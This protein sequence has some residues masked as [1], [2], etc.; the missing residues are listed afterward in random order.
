MKS[1][2][3]TSNEHPS[4]NGKFVHRTAE[5]SEK[6]AVGE[7]TKVWNNAQIREQASVG[8]NCIIGKNA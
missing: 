6:A 2:L 4:S 5:V 1:A 8:R 7:G 3:P